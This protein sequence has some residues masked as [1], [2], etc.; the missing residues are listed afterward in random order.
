MAS[1]ISINVGSDKDS[2]RLKALNDVMNQYLHVVN[3]IMKYSSHGIHQFSKN[4]AFN[5]EMYLK[6]VYFKR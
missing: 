6:I 4:F 3:K 1:Q 2:L 5:H